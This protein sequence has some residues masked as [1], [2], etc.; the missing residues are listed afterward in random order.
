MSLAKQGGTP[1]ATKLIGSSQRGGANLSINQ[2]GGEGISTTGKQPITR[3]TVLATIQNKR[4]PLITILIQEERIHQQ[5][6][7]NKTIRLIN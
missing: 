3:E 7:I 2:T 6:P 5:H 4:Q 1:Q